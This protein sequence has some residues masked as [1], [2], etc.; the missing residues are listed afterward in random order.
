MRCRSN[1]ND[2]SPNRCG[3]YRNGHC[4]H[5]IQVNRA[6]ADEVNRPTPARL[7]NTDASGL[8]VLAFSADVVVVRSHEPGR[9]AETSSQRD[10]PL[11]Y[12]PRWGPLWV[13]SKLGWYVSF[14]AGRP[15]RTTHFRTNL[16]TR[17]ATQL[18]SRVGEFTLP[19]VD[20][21]P[22]A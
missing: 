15:I 3:L 1:G 13:Q 22:R 12:R 16:T 6:L 10:A 9:V 21:V 19:S 17:C 7:K 8:V 4:P 18:L 5:W 11:T 2:S 20:L 14:M